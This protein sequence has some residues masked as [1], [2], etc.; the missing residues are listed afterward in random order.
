MKPEMT[1]MQ[2]ARTYRRL[3]S[4][5]KFALL[6]E[7]RTALEELA[8]KEREE[9]MAAAYHDEFVTEQIANLDYKELK[10]VDAALNRLQSGTFGKC[11]ECGCLIAARRLHALPWAVR[12]LECEERG[13]PAGASPTDQPKEAFV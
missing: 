2:N 12:C 8:A 4:A 5:R 6:S 11:Q 10:L 3:L 13:T 1:P 9:D 7:L